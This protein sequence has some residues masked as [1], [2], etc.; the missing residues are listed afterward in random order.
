MRSRAGEVLAVVVDRGQDLLN[1]R[2]LEGREVVELQFA[3]GRPCTGGVFGIQQF[4][5]IV[6]LLPHRCAKLRCLTLAVRA[7][8]CLL[9]D[10]GAGQKNCQQQCQASRE[11]R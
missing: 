2:T 5:G 8:L 4:N 3:N 7:F 1:T 10:Y 9:R 6:D 11:P